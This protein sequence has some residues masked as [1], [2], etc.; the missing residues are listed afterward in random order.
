M[1]KAA[2]ALFK[3]AHENLAGGGEI[4]LWTPQFPNWVQIDDIYVLDEGREIVCFKEVG[5]PGYAYV[6]M[7]DITG[8]RII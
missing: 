3:L 7:T 1:T 4:W 8:V 2:E 6:A 5:Q